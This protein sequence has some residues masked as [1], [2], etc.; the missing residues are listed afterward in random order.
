MIER[1]FTAGG[2]ILM[3][4]ESSLVVFLLALVITTVMEASAMVSHT[5]SFVISMLT[6]LLVD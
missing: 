3:H 1:P 4:F 6:Q 2:G 5:M